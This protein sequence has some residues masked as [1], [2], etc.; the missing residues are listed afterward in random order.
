MEIKHC[1]LVLDSRYIIELIQ[2][3]K[4]LS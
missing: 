3:P 2:R 1:M 4:K